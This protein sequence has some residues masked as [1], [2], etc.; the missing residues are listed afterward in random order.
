MVGLS[1]GFL[2]AIT[3]SNATGGQA[4]E[5]R[6]EV[7][8]LDPSQRTAVVNIAHNAK[9]SIADCAAGARRLHSRLI[10]PDR[11][12]G[13]D[14]RLQHPFRFPPTGSPWH[15][16]SQLPAAQHPL[17]PVEGRLAGATD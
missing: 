16:G 17:G 1:N 5:A 2:H 11:H 6:I 12:C 8:P 14:A 15:G 10:S 4:D 9:V 3:V 13:C 7:E